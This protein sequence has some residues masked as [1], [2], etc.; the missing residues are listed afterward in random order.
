MEV[1]PAAFPLS[2]MTIALA[3]EGEAADAKARL[4]EGSPATLRRVAR[5]EAAVPPAYAGARLAFI[6]IPGPEAVDAAAAARAAGAL[7]Q[8]G[9]P[10]RALR[11]Q[12]PSHRGS[13]GGGGGR[14]HWRRRASAGRGT[15]AGDRGALAR[16][17]RRRSDAATR[18]AGRGPCGLPGCRRPAGVAASVA[19]RR[20]ASPGDGGRGWMRPWRSP[21]GR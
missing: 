4:F 13:G 3:G 16:G 2:G 9:G 10:A 18:V 15:P 14:R 6:A 21:G 1:F 7:G 12:H 5:S 11:L 19:G 20:G 8:R 17:A